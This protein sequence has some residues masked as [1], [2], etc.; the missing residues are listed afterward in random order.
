MLVS[1][2]VSSS[3]SCCNHAFVSPSSTPAP[4]FVVTATTAN[5]LVQQILND[6]YELFVRR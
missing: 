3:Y 6:F 5:S 2:L 1:V 4:T